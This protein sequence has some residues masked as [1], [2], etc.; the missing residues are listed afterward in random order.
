MRRKKIGPNGYEQWSEAFSRP[1]SAENAAY[2]VRG[3][4]DK[5]NYPTLFNML[6][7]YITDSFNSAQSALTDATSNADMVFALKRLNAVY[8]ISLFFR[9]IKWINSTDKSALSDSL[10]KAAI[11]TAA[12]LKSQTTDPDILFECLALERTANG[13]I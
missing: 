5:H 3:K 7:D 4:C 9:N 2:M 1:L 10:K 8:R 13:E 11:A 6:S 12:K